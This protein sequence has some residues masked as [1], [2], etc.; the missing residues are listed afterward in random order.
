MHL[1]MCSLLLGKFWV[2]HSHYHVHL[3]KSSYFSWITLYVE[4]AMSKWYWF[5]DRFSLHIFMFVWW[6]HDATSTPNLCEQ[7]QTSVKAHGDPR[8]MGVVRCDWICSNNFTLYWGQYFGCIW[9]EVQ[10]RYMSLVLALG[11]EGF[12]HFP[13]VLGSIFWVHWKEFQLRYTGLGI[14]LGDDGALVLSFLCYNV[15]H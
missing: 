6:C 7:V 1:H 9:K 15:N 4:H 11:D 2:W 3:T 8:L 5:S 14:D 10:L 12:W 13:W